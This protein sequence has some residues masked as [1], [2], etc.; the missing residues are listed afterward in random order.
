M[1]RMVLASV[2][3]ATS[4]S[5]DEEVTGRSVFPLIQDRHGLDLVLED[6]MHPHHQHVELAM[7]GSGISKV[8][9]P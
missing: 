4:P 5:I 9:Q 7:D 8:H 1:T 6:A 3:D 2:N